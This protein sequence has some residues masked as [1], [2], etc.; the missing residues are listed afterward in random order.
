MQ[1]F[2][3]GPVSWSLDLH[4]NAVPPRRYVLGT[5]CRPLDLPTAPRIRCPS[6]CKLWSNSTKRVGQYG[7][8]TEM[9]VI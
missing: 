9:S 2:K 8:I 5:N 1:I 3:F 7:A 6:R 4:C